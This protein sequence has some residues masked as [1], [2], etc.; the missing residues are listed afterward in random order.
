MKSNEA[1]SPVSRR[2]FLTRSAMAAAAVSIVP[3][4]VLGGA[5]YVAPSENVNIAIIGAGGQGRTNVRALFQEKDAQIIAVADPIEHHDLTPFY[6]KGS[7]GR[8]PVIAEIEQEYQK[9]K[10]GFRCAEYIDFREMLEKEKAIDAILC[11]TPDH[12]HAYVTVTA[13]RLGKHV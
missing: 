4:H 8:K 9:A 1:P 13:M 11:A 7:A 10:P 2:Q 5:K 6:Y 12:N 3:R